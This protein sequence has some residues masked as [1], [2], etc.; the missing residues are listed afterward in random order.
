MRILIISKVFYPEISPRAFRTTQ[1]A[2]EFTRLGHDV[3]VMLPNIDEEF[4]REYTRNC[5]VKFKNLGTTRFDKFKSE[6]LIIRIIKRALQLSIEFPDMELVSLIKKG[7]KN[8][9]DYDLLISIAVPHPIHWGV[10]ASLKSNK[11]L[12]KKWIADCGDPFMGCKTDYYK[13]FFYF[14]YVEKNWCKQCDYIVVPTESSIEGYYP[15]FSNKIKVIPQGFDFDEIEIPEYEKNDISTF[16]Y[17][18]SLTLHFRNPY[19]F[20]DFLTELNSD[21]KFIVYNESDI[22]EPYVE[23]L[24]GKL[25]IRKYV[26]RSEL[27]PV[28]A[29][30]DF[31]INF[32]NNTSIQIPSKLIDYSISNRPVLNIDK[33]LDKNV[34]LQFLNGN[35]DGQMRLLDLEKYNIR[36]V[37]QSFLTL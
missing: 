17:A 2:Q 20:L 35:Y 18:G 27:I 36:N 13:K 25:E 32:S 22:L 5:G 26:P 14:K 29:G 6:N 21:F 34:V 4:Y 12:T 23:R 19:P 11:I 24:K 9:S 37:A 10:A 1:L 7:L 16:A 3:T 28:L 33:D 31:L 30:V 15:E 8:Q